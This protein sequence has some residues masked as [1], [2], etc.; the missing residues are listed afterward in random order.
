MK[1]I[2]TMRKIISAITVATVLTAAASGAFAA[3]ASKTV[4]GTVKSVTANVLT[5][6]DGS[7]YSLPKAFD[8]K[9]IKKGEKVDIAYVLVGKKMEATT[10]KA[11]TV[12]ATSVKAA[13]D[14]S[15]PAAAAPSTTTTTKP[16]TAN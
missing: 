6:A 2:K 9:A 4:T 7:H 14:A 5:L 16:T 1:G 12:K 8:I 3:A 11:V 15:A 13:P 10:V